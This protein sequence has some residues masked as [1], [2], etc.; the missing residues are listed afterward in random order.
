VKRLGD[1]TTEVFG[2]LAEGERP[3]VVLVPVG[4]LEPHGP[5]LPLATDTLIS[6][7]AAAAAVPLLEARVVALVAPSVAHG[8]TDCARSFPGAV[9]IP[10]SILEGYLRALVEGH[11]AAG[12]AHV[13]LVNSHLEP[14][15]DRAVRDAARAVGPPRASVASPLLPRWGRTLSEEFQ[16]GA[17]HA[18]RYETSLLL[19]SDPSHVD[20]AC[21]R[22]LPDVEVSLSWCL[23]RGVNDF[24][25]MGL[26]RGY[27]GS[28]RAATAE[29][30]RVLLERL[31]RMVA[32]EVLEA[33]GESPAA[34]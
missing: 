14:A 5:H 24:L 8:V 23:R 21:R 10:A 4:S 6:E 29:E 32:T 25:A 7:A 20:D 9:S 27:A 2:K 16:R 17:C 26:T 31:G 28:P 33:L 30:G 15:H 22:E 3:L 11:L 34:R 19:A 13:C 12:A 1:L 18:G